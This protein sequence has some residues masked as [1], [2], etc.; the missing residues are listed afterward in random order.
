MLRKILI[1]LSSALFFF[2]FSQCTKCTRKPIENVIDWRLVWKPAKPS[3]N[4]LPSN[5]DVAKSI[6]CC[7]P[8]DNAVYCINPTGECWKFTETSEGPACESINSLPGSSSQKALFAFSAGATK[9]TQALHVGIVT[10]S[11]I[12]LQQYTPEGWQAIGTFNFSNL[13]I[14][15]PTL[16]NNP[17]VHAAACSLREQGQ[18]NGLVA[19][20]ID[21]D[22]PKLLLYDTKTQKLSGST[23]WSYAYHSRTPI[24]LVQLALGEVLLLYKEGASTAKASI[25]REKGAYVVSFDAYPEYINLCLLEAAQFPLKK[26]CL[27]C[28]NK[29]PIPSGTTVVV[30]KFYTF[31]SN[32]SSLRQA[33]DLPEL[34]E[35]SEGDSKKG[36]T[37]PVADHS[38]GLLLPFAHQLF[39][40]TKGS[41]GNAVYYTGALG[42]PSQKNKF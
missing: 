26:V 13:G 33:D 15:S 19:L 40:I 14:N 2:A 18:L 22:A 5:L 41:K 28:Y 7:V 23:T 9:E 32:N 25:L 36:N 3:A 21:A 27:V 24:A 29:K 11:N 20:K 37:P 38:N 39:F 8:P 17:M 30:P 12:I 42:P 31:D 16:P 1:Y 10:A 35:E 6:N 4:P 34:P